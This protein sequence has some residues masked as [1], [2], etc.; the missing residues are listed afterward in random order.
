M[1]LIFGDPKSIELRDIAERDS[2]IKELKDKICCPFCKA[3]IYNWFDWDGEEKVIGWYFKCNNN[4][5]N[6]GE[7]I[8]KE[9]RLYT[10]Y[11]GKF[12]YY[13]NF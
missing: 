4:C 10:D 6:S 13:D 11:K 3:P 9:Q 7:I 5:I 8:G 12:V 2:I 1:K